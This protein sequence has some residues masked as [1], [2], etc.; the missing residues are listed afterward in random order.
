M[1]NIKML[2]RYEIKEYD[3]IS[4]QLNYDI[5]FNFSNSR[6]NFDSI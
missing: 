1:L 6:F 3:L 5:N 4:L 2:D